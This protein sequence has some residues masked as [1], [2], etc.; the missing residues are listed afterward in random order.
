M[1]FFNVVMPTSAHQASCGLQTN[2]PAGSVASCLGGPHKRTSIWYASGIPPP[3][4]AESVSLAAVGRLPR[5]PGL[6]VPSAASRS[7]SQALSSAAASSVPRATW[8]VGDLTLAAPFP[9][10]K[11]RAL[12]I[13]F[14]FLESGESRLAGARLFIYHLR[15]HYLTEIFSLVFLQSSL[16]AARADN[17]YYPPEWSPKKV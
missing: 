12:K 10:P 2:P 17:F 15:L 16:A 14:A 3:F 13:L 6:T 7:P 1:T 11:P 8:Y 4:N 5:D 9:I